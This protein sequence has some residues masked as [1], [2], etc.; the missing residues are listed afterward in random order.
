MRG[1]AADA[2]EQERLRRLRASVEERSVE[3]VER[4]AFVAVVGVAPA[5]AAAMGGGGRGRGA[6]AAGWRRRGQKRSCR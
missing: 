5:A 6:C 1:A 3:V 2:A 4:R